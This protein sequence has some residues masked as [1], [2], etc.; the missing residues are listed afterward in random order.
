MNVRALLIAG[1]LSASMIPGSAG[2][3]AAQ[4]G[5]QGS[6]DVLLFLEREQEGAHRRRALLG[7]F[8]I[9][10]TGADTGLLHAP[11]TTPD[12]PDCHSSADAR[13]F[14]AKRGNS[15]VSLTCHWEKLP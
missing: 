13:R 15:D 5:R 14:A 10:D 9:R 12:D 3:S 4:V 6:E 7:R 1:V 2:V 8:T 11:S